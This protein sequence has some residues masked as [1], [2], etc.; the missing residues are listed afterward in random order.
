MEFFTHGFFGQ[1]IAPAA[2]FGL[3][4]LEIYKISKQVVQNCMYNGGVFDYPPTWEPYLPSTVY[5][6]V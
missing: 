6:F 2:A 4:V 3:E 5:H 1:G